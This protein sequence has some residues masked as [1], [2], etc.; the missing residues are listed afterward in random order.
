MFHRVEWKPVVRAEIHLIDPRARAGRVGA[1]DP[2]TCYWRTCV[3][4]I[5]PSTQPQAALCQQ[6][7][8]HDYRMF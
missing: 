7:R 8:V 6:N 4:M 5:G 2:V 3:E 1:H